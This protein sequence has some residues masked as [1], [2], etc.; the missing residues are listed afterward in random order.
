MNLKCVKRKTLLAVLKNMGFTRLGVGQAGHDLFE[1]K[2]TQRQISASLHTADM[3]HMGKLYAIGME[4]ES[5][6]I[7]TRREFIENLRNA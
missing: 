5:K 4:M 1:H 2:L 7:A 3:I 6:G